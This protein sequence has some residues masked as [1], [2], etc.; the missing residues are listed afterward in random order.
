VAIYDRAVVKLSEVG[1]MSLT[2]A[3]GF[4]EVLDDLR[5]AIAS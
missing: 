3:P 4:V 1:N 2:D 5:V